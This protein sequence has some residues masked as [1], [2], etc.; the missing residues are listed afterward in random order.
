MDST[1]AYNAVACLVE[2]RLRPGPFP[3][4]PEAFRPQDLVQAYDLQDALCTALTEAGLG[5]KVG[6]KIGCTSRIMQEYMDIPH[7]CSGNIFQNNVFQISMDKPAAS[8]HHIGVECE[9]AVK[10]LEDIPDRKASYT[11]TSVSRHIKS[12]MAAIE[13]VDDRY[14]NFRELDIET[15]VADD[16]FQAACVLGQEIFEWE[17]LDF[18]Q[19]CGRM[20]IN[21]E[22]TGQGRGTDILGHPF[23][24]LAWLANHKLARNQMLLKD[25]I[26]LL[27]SV[28]KTQWLAAGDRVSIEFDDLGTVSAQFSS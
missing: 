7:P 15:I 28:V 2:N 14:D 3:G 19:I 9:I 20:M 16:F 23:E 8:Y 24:A 25:E 27:G 4:L 6:H 26:V 17:K 21:D 18:S 1:L 13:I 11:A 10:I 5:R 12:C 22:K